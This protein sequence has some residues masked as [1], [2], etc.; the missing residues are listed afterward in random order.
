MQIAIVKITTHKTTIIL[1]T[2]TL[3]AII[4]IMALAEVTSLD[5]LVVVDFTD[6]YISDQL[7][8]Q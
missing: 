2:T 7:R 6:H 1:I 4:I 3:K 5:S 8:A